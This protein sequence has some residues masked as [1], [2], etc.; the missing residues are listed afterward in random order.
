MNPLDAAWAPGAYEFERFREDLY[1]RI[2]GTTSVMS[3]ALDRDANTITTA[4]QRA[5]E[6]GAL[7]P[8]RAD[9]EYAKVADIAEHER[10]V[11][12]WTLVMLTTRTI[13]A[14]KHLTLVADKLAPKYHRHGKSDLEKLTNEFQE[15]YNITLADATTGIA[16]L[17]GM[18]IARNKIVHNASALYEL[19]SDPNAI[20]AE[21][22]PAWTPKPADQDF[23]QHYPEYADGEHIT[24]TKHVF[25]QRAQQALDFIAY[26]TERFDHFIQLLA[27]PTGTPS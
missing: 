25:E 24:I 21:G 9:I 16:F 4:L 12:N 18:R 2:W 19:T 20:L 22:E 7:H 17:E 5:S 26:A 11:Y 3:H 15:R 14:L 6:A 8:D 27:A 13:D 23:L 10:F 1:L